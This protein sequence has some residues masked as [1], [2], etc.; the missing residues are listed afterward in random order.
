MSQYLV[1]QIEATPNIKV[2]LNSSVKSV[3]GEGRLE[4]VTIANSATK[5]DA[6]V[7]ATALFIFIGAAP[8][9][10]WVAGVLERDDM[11]TTF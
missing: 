1:D 10:E 3:Q 8:L 4:S 6:T 11:T 2:L 7:P 9:T 5:Q